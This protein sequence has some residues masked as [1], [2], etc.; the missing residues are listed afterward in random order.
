[1][2]VLI[3]ASG[4]GGH[5]FPAIALAQ[6]LTKK[7]DIEIIFAASK[8]TLDKN[9]L[10]KKKYKKFFFSINPMPYTLG[11][12]AV[13]FLLRFLYDVLLS[14]YVLLYTRPHVVVGF[15][16]YTSGSV[17]LLASFLGIKGIIHEQNLVPGRANRI[18]DRF[19][20]SIAVS[21]E[22]TKKFFKN[23]N[24]ILTGNPLRKGISL[25]DKTRSSDSLGLDQNKFTMLVMGGSQGARSLNRLVSSAIV[26]LGRDIIDKLQI[27]HIAGPKDF[28]GLSRLYR[29]NGVSAKTFSFLDNIYDAY[30]ACDLAVSRSGAAAICELSLYAKPMVLIPYPFKK[31]NQRFNAKYF[32]EKGAAVYKEEA[33]LDNNKL[34]HIL[35]DLVNDEGRLQR[36]SNNARILACPDAT[37]KLAEEVLKLTK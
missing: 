20:K 37:M 34:S 35:N 11:F 29:D 13:P 32:A 22:D 31:N 16:G 3:A 23:S 36:L 25:S 33:D 15:G 6:E 18:L 28:E 9:I 8:R 24:V 26:H 12:K 17:I 7:T 30:G 14:L 21:F 10:E 19:V 5:I 1:M 27:I 4:S 2:K